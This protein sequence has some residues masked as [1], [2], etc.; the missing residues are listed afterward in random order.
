MQLDAFTSLFPGSR[1]AGTVD[2]PPPP[3]LTQVAL[4]GVVR[5]FTGAAARDGARR[6]PPADWLSVYLVFSASPDEESAWLAA[7]DNELWTAAHFVRRPGLAELRL[8]FAR[9]ARQLSQA[10]PAVRSLHSVMPGILRSGQL[11]GSYVDEGL[12]RPTL[13]RP[14]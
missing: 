1:I 9:A 7:S 2:R 3:A 11:P 13:R 4:L 10:G 12:R 6:R 14:S 5:A 8:N